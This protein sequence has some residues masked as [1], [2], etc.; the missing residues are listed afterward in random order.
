[1]NTGVRKITAYRVISIILLII[2]AIL[3]AFP[4]YW[5]L[6]G[7]L[8][9]PAAINAASPEW[10]P[11][12]FT[13]RNF[14]VLFT[15][16]SAPLYELPI[17]F[18]KLKVVGATVPAAVRW[19][20]NTVFMA[21]MAMVLTCITAAAAAY[22]LANLVSDE[23]LNADYIIPAAFD[24]RVKDAVAKAVAQAAIDSGVARI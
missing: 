23:E 16:R 9:T 5:I 22:A 12:E 21:V 6:T 2:F 1:M 19:L 14:Q 18:T 15:K 11:H 7:A 24:P 20:A 17:P 8:K 13:L 3:F 10:F 4:L